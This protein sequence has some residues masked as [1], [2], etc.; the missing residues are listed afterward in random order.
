MRQALI[1]AGM[2]LAAM[3]PA[4][5]LQLLSE[6]NPPYNFSQQG[7]PVGLYVEVVQAIQHRLGQ[8]AS[9]QI[10]PWPRAYRTALNTPDV[11]LFATTRTPER[12]NLFQ[13][14]GPIG[15]SV[16]AFFALR[17]NTLIIRNLHDAQ[18]VSGILVA[19]DSFAQQTLTG[20]GF[21]NLI[22]AENPKQSIRMLLAGR[23]PLLFTGRSGLL[24]QLQHLNEPYN[25]LKLSYVLS[26]GQ[27]YIAFS[28]G[29]DKSIVTDWQK[30]LDS[31]KKSGQFRRIYG[32]WLPG[33][34]P[35]GITPDPAAWPNNNPA[36]L[37]H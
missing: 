31:L 24:S 36:L 3:R 11:A 10:Q 18:A 25:Q 1:V 37:P 4:V 20:L 34:K 27:G 15:T 8:E 26:V 14:V 22:V 19:K 28:A 21:N 13:W 12:E 33:E 30:A 7:R 16:N 29:T 5:G 9:I 23:A 35:S 6:E 32:K 2:L 17:H